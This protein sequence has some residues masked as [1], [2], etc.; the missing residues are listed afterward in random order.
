ME[1]PA[2]HLGVTHWSSRLLAAELGISNFTVA[3]VWQRWGLQPWRAETFKFSTDP[4]LEAKIRDVVRRQGIT[5]RET[6]DLVSIAVAN[7]DVS[8]SIGQQRGCVLGEV[9][10]KPPPSFGGGARFVVARQ[11]EPGGQLGVPPRPAVGA[12]GLRVVG[13]AHPPHQPT[14]G[15]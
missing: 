9:V 13:G 2:E 5:T 14:M 12:A 7:G 4:E 11:P 8:A 1:E 15:A 3:R 10:E 6:S